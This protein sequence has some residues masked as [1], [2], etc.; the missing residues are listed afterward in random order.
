[1]ETLGPLT[2]L[3]YIHVEGD[4]L[5]GW[6]QF[7]LQTDQIAMDCTYSF[8][9]CTV[10]YKYNG[11]KYAH[12][13]PPT[14][15]HLSHTPLP[16]HT[17]RQGQVH[18][19]GVRRLYGLVWLPPPRCC[20]EPTVPLCSRR[21]IT[22]DIHTRRHQKGTTCLTYNVQYMFRDSTLCVSALVVMVVVGTNHL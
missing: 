13:P 4:L 20:H 7:R 3:Y 9:L 11:R 15:A 2:W 16:P 19:D 17:H 14:H 22:R 5:I 8:L 18:R 21:P 10:Q 1:M 12:T 6:P